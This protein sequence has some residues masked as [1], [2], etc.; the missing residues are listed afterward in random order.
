MNIKL[1]SATIMTAAIVCAVT[2]G[3]ADACYHG[4]PASYDE[5]DELD[6][7]IYYAPKGHTI[8]RTKYC[9]GQICPPETRLL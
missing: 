2:D 9:C 3:K 5:I 4:C 7:C 8:E 6:N 1:A